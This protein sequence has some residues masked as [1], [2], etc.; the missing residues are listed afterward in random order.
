MG[1]GS[2]WPASEDLPDMAF[3]RHPHQTRTLRTTAV[4]YRK[5]RVAVRWNN[6]EEKKEER[7]DN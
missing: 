4:S 5:K 3:A 1:K 2:S 7:T 6:Y